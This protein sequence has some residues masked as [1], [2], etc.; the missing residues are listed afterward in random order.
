MGDYRIPRFS[1]VPPIDT[2]YLDNLT[3]G[4]MPRGRGEMPLVPTVGTIANAVYDAVGLRFHT[5]PMTPERVLEGL[6]RMM[7]DE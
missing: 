6:A 4:Q 3:N 7:N 5:L 2:V 1:D